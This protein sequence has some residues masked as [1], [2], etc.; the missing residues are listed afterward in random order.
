M[1]EKKEDLIDYSRLEEYG[2]EETSKELIELYKEVAMKDIIELAEAVEKKNC[3]DIERLAHDLKGCSA[4][5]GA[6]VVA[7]L[8]EH[9]VV[10]ARKNQLEKSQETYG[11][12]KTKYDET[13]AEW[14]KLY[15]L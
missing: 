14:T 1:A 5:I 12:L 7:D 2:D 6:V 15:N 10:M 11:Q 8:S 4:N 3:G 13:I 9:L